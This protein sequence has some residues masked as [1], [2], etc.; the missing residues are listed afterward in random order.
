MDMKLWMPFEMR[1]TMLAIAMQERFGA[2]ATYQSCANSGY[3]ADEAIDFLSSR[4]KVYYSDEY[5]RFV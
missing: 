1:R 2:D 5:F 4:G 3:A